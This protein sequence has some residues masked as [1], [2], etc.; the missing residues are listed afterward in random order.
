MEREISQLTLLGVRRVREILS[1]S[2]GNTLLRNAFQEDW[3]ANWTATSVLNDDGRLEAVCRLVEMES[4]VVVRRLDR[5]HGKTMVRTV[6]ARLIAKLDG[7]SDAP[8]PDAL[9]EMSVTDAREEGVVDDV[10]M[11]TGLLATTVEARLRN[12]HGRTLIKNLFDARWPADGE[13]WQA[14]NS[15]TEA[16]EPEEGD[17]DGEPDDQ[18]AESEE[19]DASAGYADRDIDGLGGLT[20]AT[21]RG[22]EFVEQISK[23]T[24]LMTSTVARKM[25]DAHGKTLVRNL[26][27]N[28]WPVDD[29]ETIDEEGEEE[30]QDE[31]SNV[32]QGRRA[33]RELQ[34]SLLDLGRLMRFHVRQN[35]SIGGGFRPDVMWYRLDPN[36]HTKASPT[37]VF[38]IEFGQ[39]AQLAK[40]FASLKHAHD[41]C[42]AELFLIVPQTRLNKART[43]AG[44]AEMNAISHGA[45]HEISGR[46]K[47]LP[48]EDCAREPVELAEALGLPLGH[49]L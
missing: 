46:L 16:E 39:S 27:L 23:V 35:H 24:G 11:I 3:P 47:I 38:E 36:E 45:F 10:V 43:K 15:G 32:G 5:C 13:A 37:H 31:R 41:L 48:V 12:A 18:E 49:R 20:V 33:H 44:A 34:R 9:G 4:A 29:E 17:Q 19:D 28:R 25:G 1:S 42:N 6:F 22:A 26:F 7:A 14:E 21:A 40:S 2:A 8:D 30:G